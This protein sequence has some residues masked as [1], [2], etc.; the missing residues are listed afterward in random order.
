MWSWCGKR[1]L[2]RMRDLR[3][4]SW[5][6]TSLLED[7]LLHFSHT[8]CL[9]LSFLLL[10]FFII[11][12]ITYTRSSISSFSCIS[13]FHPSLSLPVSL[14][15]F[16]FPLVPLFSVSHMISLSISPL[17]R[18]LSCPLWV[19]VDDV[20]GVGMSSECHLSVLICGCPV[21]RINEGW[22]GWGLPDL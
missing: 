14:F 7:D 1:K 12:L 8:F 17:S 16:P 20:D 22:D 2:D 13:L 21:E 9:Y 5:E 18:S 3:L 15:L 10:S 19:D 4:R 6:T 11:T